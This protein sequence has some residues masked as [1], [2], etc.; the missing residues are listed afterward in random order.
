MKLLRSLRVTTTPNEEDSEPFVSQVLE[1]DRAGN[2]ISRLEFTAHET[3]EAKTETVYNADNRII[4]VT[5]FLDEQ[6]IAERKKYDRN[7]EGRIEQVNIEFTDGSLSVQSIERDDKNR[8]E[9]WIERDEDGE[10]ESREF[11]K[12][13]EQGKVILKETYDFNDKLTEAFEYEYHPDGE[14]AIRRQLDQRRKLIIE[15]EYKY[16]D[17]GLLILRVSRNRRG[18][19]SDFLKIEYNEKGLPVK[20]SFSGKYTF[21][22]EY[23]DQGNTVMEEQYSGDTL[24]NRI[25]S[26]YDENNRVIVEEQFKFSRHFEYEYYD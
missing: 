3:F 5:T 12:F 8:T 14:M 2:E 6:E 17:T 19:L 25:T 15:T 22:F 21:L 9:N 11:L 20:Q 10:L 18:E 4:E 1:Y 7:S 26:E 24:D 23:D 16:S 13:N